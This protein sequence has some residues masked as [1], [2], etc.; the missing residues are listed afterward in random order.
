MIDCKITLASNGAALLP[1]HSNALLFGYTA[2]R[3]VYRLVLDATG[4]WQNLTIRAVWHTP[5]SKAPTSSLVVDGVMDVPAI[6]TAQPGCGCITF[7]GTDGIRTVT[8]ADVGYKVAAN[9]GLEDGTLPEPGSPAWQELIRSIKSGELKGDQ[10]EPGATGPQ[11][12][13]GP[14]GE[15]GPQGPKGEPGKDGISPTIAVTDIDGGHRITISDAD[16]AAEV[17]VPNGK[18]AAIDTTLTR[19]GE[20]ADAKAAGEAIGAVQARQNILTGTETG[21]V[22]SIDDAFAAP[23]C[24]LTVYGRSTQDGTPSPENPVPIISAGDSGSVVVKVT[25]K[26]LF[27]ADALLGEAQNGEYVFVANTIKDKELDVIKFKEN[28]QYTLSFDAYTEQNSLAHDNIGVMFMTYYTDGTTDS[29]IGFVN[30]SNAQSEYTHKSGTTQ[31]GKTVAKMYLSFINGGFNVWHFKNIQLELGPTATAYEPYHEQ[32]L[33]LSTPDGLPGIPV[34]SGGSYTDPSGQ[35]WVCDEIDL[36]SK[37]KIKRIGLKM[38]SETDV[39]W[40]SGISNKSTGDFYGIRNIVVKSESHDNR[41]NLICNCYTSEK[42]HSFKVVDSIFLSGEDTATV[43][44]G[45]PYEKFETI[46][47][48]KDA[49]ISQN[50]KFLYVMPNHIETPL[51]DEEI[52]AYKTLAT[53]G[54]NTLVQTSGS[55]GMQLVYQRDVNIVVKNLSDAL[56]QAH[57]DALDAEETEPDSADILEA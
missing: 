19:A 17:D 28:T 3:G 4:E 18:D 48:F 30:T 41:A 23:L 8:S 7:E 29:H 40:K 24:G 42:N 13:T 16:G 32:L 5:A 37:I 20:A 11:G 15:Q 10:G 31:E 50:C 33:T 56:A 57:Y 14:R 52:A 45:T 12:E 46:D 49:L 55:A 34:T 43:Y 27:H 47:D 35:Q 54:P 36:E 2:N 9:S 22:L 53:Y 21:S 44:F 38:I 51:T 26:N 39:F 6:V 1:G 25:G